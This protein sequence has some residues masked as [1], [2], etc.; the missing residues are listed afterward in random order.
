MQKGKKVPRP[1][2][3]VNWGSQVVGCPSCQ[4]S[5]FSEIG[6]G[7]VVPAEPE[8]LPNRLKPRAKFT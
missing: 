4:A 1:K 2:C 6:V 3:F 8:L 5:L 7:G